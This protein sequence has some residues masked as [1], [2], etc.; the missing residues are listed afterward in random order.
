MRLQQTYFTNDLLEMLRGVLTFI[1]TINDFNIF[2]KK[3][4][5]AY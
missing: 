3:R 1:N 5:F 2:Q 4:Y